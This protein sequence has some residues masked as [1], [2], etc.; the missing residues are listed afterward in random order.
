MKKKMVRVTCLLL[1]VI[2]MLCPLS[3]CFAAGEE[4][5]VDLANSMIIDLLWETL[6]AWGINIVETGYN[7]ITE[8]VRYWLS[9]Q[10]YEYLENELHETFDYFI[11]GMQWYRDQFGRLIGND[12]YV[13]AADAFANHLRIAFGITSNT[14]T[15]LE[16]IQYYNGIELHEFPVYCWGERYTSG[17]VQTGAGESLMR[18]DSTGDNNSTIYAVFT[19]PNSYGDRFVAVSKGKHSSWLWSIKTVADNFTIISSGGNLAHKYFTIG[20]TQYNTTQ[21]YSELCPSRDTQRFTFNSDNFYNPQVISDALSVSATITRRGVVAHSGNIELA[22]DNPNYE[23]GYS[24]IYYP[25]GT[26]GYL[27]IEWPSTISVDNLPAIVST[28]TV[29]NPGIQSVFLPI[30]SF[31]TT[32]ED[33]FGLMTQLVYNLPSEIVGMAL[34]IM[35]AII[36]FG[37]IRIMKEH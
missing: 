36:I 29:E 12:E 25:D 33:G 32:F 11:T 22:S 14:T 24:I 37:T 2:V 9:G 26:V 6:K 16:V 30:K 35:G 19:T 23:S 15:E 28:G 21:F 20:N 17:G 1:A 8:N 4:L 27:D 10:L 31:I 5:L 7:E 13:R 34:A 3:V 18:I